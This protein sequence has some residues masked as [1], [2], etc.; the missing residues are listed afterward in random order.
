MIKLFKTIF[1][2]IFKDDSK[3]FIVQ[4]IRYFIT[5]GTAFIA[6]YSI[7]V[8]LKEV[9]NV[10]YLLANTISF[11]AGLFV[12]Y[13]ICKIWTFKSYKS[14]NKYYEFL[15]FFITS[16]VGLF[17][18]DFSLW[19]FKEKINIDY[20]IAKVFA[21]LIAFVW[22]FLSKKLILFNDKKDKNK[23]IKDKV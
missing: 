11:I 22:N 15:I 19:F 9:F 7:L 20:R 4:F 5:G 21:T 17:I 16:F 12:N 18:N 3:N 6:D 23:D 8:L 13:F 2:I 10:H 1:R 14:N